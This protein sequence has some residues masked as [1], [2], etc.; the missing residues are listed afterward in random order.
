MSF[1]F[2]DTAPADRYV[3]ED[4]KS[5]P[6]ILERTVAATT[7]PFINVGAGAASA[8]NRGLGA[9][10]QNLDRLSTFVSEK[11]GF[12]KGD[13]FKAASEQYAKNAEYWE[14]KVKDPS[15]IEEVLAEFL[16]GAAPG[17]AEF[18]LNVPYSAALG[19]VE[20]G[21]KGA[22]TEAGKRAAMGKILH[23]ANT[24]K[25]TP[26]VVAMGGVGATEAAA[27][28]GD[29]KDIAK[30]AGVMAG[31]G[32]A[33]GSR[34]KSLKEIRGGARGKLIKPKSTPD[35]FLKDP[36]TAFLKKE[37]GERF[38][39]EEPAKVSP[40]TKPP[41]KPKL[42]K[43][44]DKPK[45]KPGIQT[46]STKDIEINMRDLKIAEKNLKEGKLSVT[47]DAPVEVEFNIDTG[48]YT[49]TEGY[50]RLLAKR[51]GSIEKAL[52]SARK[53]EF[54]DIKADVTLIK[55]IVRD[56]FKATEKLSKQEAPKEPWENP[57]TLPDKFVYD[58]DLKHEADVHSNKGKITVGPKFFKLTIEQ[59]RGVVSH[60]VGHELSDKMI[61]DGT[62]FE[63]ADSGAFGPKAKDGTIKGINGQFTPGEN[64]AEAIAVIQTEPIWLKN[65]YP[66]AYDAIAKRLMSE[67]KPVPESVLADYPGL[68]AKQPTKKGQT[69][70][71][72][73]PVP[74]ITKALGKAGKWVWDD[75]LMTKAPKLVEKIPGGKAVLRAVDYD[76]R[77]NL[78]DTP[79]FIKALETSKRTRQI[80][81]SYGINLGKRLQSVSEADQLALG[82]YIRGEKKSLPDNLKALG[83]EAKGAML[84]LGKQAVDVGLL[85]EK[86]FFK[87]AGRYMPRLYDSKE[88]QSLLTKFNVAKPN[89]LDLSRFKQRKDIP[90]EIREQ[91][92]E[93]LT[94][95]YPIAKG[96]AQLT[97][98][99]EVA[100]WFKGISQN[101][102]WAIAKG[103]KSPAPEGW[104]KLPSE[105][106]LGALSES[107]V[108]PEAFGDI[109][110]TIRVMNTPEKVWRKALGAWKFGKVIIS[111]KTHAR[112]LMSN[113]ILAHLGG[114]PLYEQPVYLA[115]AAKEMRK[116][117]K[118]WQSATEEGLLG[119]TW[120][121]HELKGLFL[122]AENNIGGVKA[123]GIP[124]KLGLVG[125][126]WE[127]S[128]QLANKAARTYQAEEEWF[129]LSKFI[130]NIERKKM[131]PKVAAADAE[132]WLFNY[133]RVTKF[134]D[135]YRSKWFGA[136]FATFTFKALPRIAEA[137][138]KTPHRFILPAAIIYGLEKAAMEIIGD[139]PEQFKAKKELRPE[140]MKGAA[141]GTPNFARVPIVDE[142]GREHYLNLTYILPWG[143]IGESGSFAGIPGALVPLSQPFVKEAW[144]QIANYDSFYGRA[145]VPETETAGKSTIGRVKTHATLRG[146]HLAQTMLPTPV[147][148]IVK[149]A[150][151]LAGKPDYKGRL[152]SPT[153][154]AADVFAGIK[155]YPVDYA[156][157]MGRIVSKKNPKGGFLARR[158]RGEIKTFGIKRGAMKKAGKSTE[159]YDKKIAEKIKQ[160]QG[161]AKELIETGKIYGKIKGEIK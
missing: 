74:E 34:G 133:G 108:H 53:G 80:G 101:K 81:R 145:I 96:V 19:Y 111:P 61:K 64:V 54:P 107:Y 153:V 75:A 131:S 93:I 7:R 30:S 44:H 124:E 5:G 114:Q 66:K 41:A 116:K 52:A 126:A 68:R 141:L 79:G 17:M 23:A 28:G 128:K 144:Q 40:T 77:G 142:H 73:I 71:G 85:A 63:L 72:G 148:D 152:R 14:S 67:N 130:H 89:R 91:M 47:P 15:L 129:K 151:A 45:A 11:T 49:L 127:K 10:S 159:F 38:V 95:G 150:S 155:M 136:P 32:L 58:K 59:K 92:G 160:L 56:G 100:K 90:K 9:F 4:E 118:Y 156:E 50:H 99:I 60:E 122:E 158:I 84:S 2:E 117:G 82:E 55:N 149:G 48:E 51:G 132:K 121:E 35:A 22:L 6:G 106:K 33:A 147:L 110:E 70:Y 37:F 161:L 21:A 105:K 76:Y 123:G 146:K 113:S 137:A 86:T 154:V 102:Q 143:D 57:E 157:Q 12:A 69:L 42:V 46:L 31:F 97:H 27:A 83:D 18:M 104:K 120:T 109:Q 112:N 25:M 43:I 26:R 24:L 88:Y 8:L 3:F 1:V 134:Q 65:N 125:V 135:A 36:E 62:A 16:G 87:N 115:R 139:D 140:W 39:F 119:T 29:V 138:I 20:G 94:P 103:D 78:P 98:D 13:V